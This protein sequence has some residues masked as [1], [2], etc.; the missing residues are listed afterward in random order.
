MHQDAIGS[1]KATTRRRIPLISDEYLTQD[2]TKVARKTTATPML[3][4]AIGRIVGGCLRYRYTIIALSLVIS[5]VSGF[6]AAKHFAINTDIN[7]LISPNLEWRKHEIT[8]ANL[9]PGPFGTTTVVVEAPSQELVA[10]AASTLT[11]KLSKNQDLYHS[12]S[13]LGGGNA[14]FARNGL[15]FQPLEEVEHTTRM[16]AD[17]AQLIVTLARDPSLRGLTQS[18]SFVM[19]GIQGGL[20]KLD[21]ISKPL[22]TFA[23]TVETNI[24]GQPVTF[25][26]HALMNGQPSKPEDLRRFIEVRPVLDYSALE[27]GRKANDAIREAARNLPPELGARVRLTGPVPI[28]DEEFST[29]QQG[30]LVNSIATLLVVLTILW[31]ALR[32]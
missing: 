21:D 10:Q 7:K 6:Y 19:T 8:F 4:S 23:D 32:S 29:V 26:W 27:P 12:V 13:E 9:F 5:V 22:N 3:S 31:L 20:L 18:L 15:L 30:A 11:Q 2:S 16:L 17:S 25:S 14:F 24:A 28:A 1:V